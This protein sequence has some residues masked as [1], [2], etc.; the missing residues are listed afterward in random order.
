MPSATSFFVS[1]FAGKKEKY[2]KISFLGS[3]FGRSIF[4]MMNSFS[5]RLVG[6]ILP[7]SPKPELCGAPHFAKFCKHPTLPL[8][9]Y[10]FVVKN[11]KALTFEQQTIFI[12][13]LATLLFCFFPWLAVEPLYEDPYWYSAFRGATGLIGI[14]IFLFS[15][16]VSLFWLEQIFDLKKIKKLPLTPAQI[17]L[18]VGLQQILLIVLAWSVLIVVGRSFENSELRF[19]LSAA[20]LAQCVGLVAAYLQLEKD[21]QGAAREFFQHAPKTSHKKELEVEHIGGLFENTVE[22]D[23]HPK[24]S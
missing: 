23:H 4:Q 17:F 11:F 14:F 3:G 20:F 6:L 21:R 2:K 1:F 22:G 12:A 16:G 8:M 5:C 10:A 19:G 7:N 9:K 15:L 24:S 13:H 18:I